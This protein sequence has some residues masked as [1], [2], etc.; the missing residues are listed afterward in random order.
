MPGVDAIRERITALCRV[1]VIDQ[2]GGPNRVRMFSHGGRPLG[3]VPL[4]PFTAVPEIV[5]MRGD[6]LTIRATSYLVPDAWFLS[7]VR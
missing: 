4:S 1:Y 2:W 7:T 5:P 3:E 6:G